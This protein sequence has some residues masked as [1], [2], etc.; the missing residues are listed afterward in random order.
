MN[1]KHAFPLYRRYMTH[2]DKVAGLSSLYVRGMYLIQNSDRLI[3]RS[4]GKAMFY[5]REFATRAQV[6]LRPAVA[7]VVADTEN[8]RR[9]ISGFYRELKVRK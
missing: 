8:V 9:W 7:L 6:K 5:F 2:M 3:L 4:C 1:F